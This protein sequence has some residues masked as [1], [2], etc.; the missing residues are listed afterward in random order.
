M[1]TIKV[2][3]FPI[4]SVLKAIGNP[5]IDYFSLDIEGAELQVTYNILMGDMIQLSTPRYI[6]YNANVTNEFFVQVLQTIPWDLVDIKLFG[7]ETE[8]AGD[9]SH[10]TVKDIIRHMKN[11]GYNKKD[12]IGHDTFFVKRQY[13][14]IQYIIC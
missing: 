1:R 10:G 5:R 9:L 13:A 2:Q 14:S 8:H 12:K 7:I 11:V 4:Y 3:C 6:E